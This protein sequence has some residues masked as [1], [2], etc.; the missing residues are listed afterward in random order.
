MD[1][2]VDLAFKSTSKKCLKFQNQEK[3]TYH[4]KPQFHVY[5]C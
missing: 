3:L 2:S 4:Q 1:F 5:D